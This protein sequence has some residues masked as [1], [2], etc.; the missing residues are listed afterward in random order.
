VLACE[1]PEGAT[2]GST[3]HVI[4]PAN[5]YY[6]V[7]VPENAAPGDTINILFEQQEFEG[8]SSPTEDAPARAEKKSISARLLASLV[9][10]SLKLHQ[11]A[12][13]IDND[14]K[15]TEKVTEKVT[16][17][18]QKYEISSKT[19]AF[20]IPYVERATVLD[21]EYKVTERVMATG[22]RICVFAKE[23]DEKYA[24]SAR[25]G[26]FVTVSRGKIEQ[27]IETAKVVQQDVKGSIPIV[28]ANTKEA[29]NT[30]IAKAQ[31]T[32]QAAIA[33]V[34]EQKKA[35]VV[36][37]T[38]AVN[39]AMEKTMEISTN[40]SKMALD[41]GVSALDKAISAAGGLREYVHNAS[42]SLE[43]KESHS[44]GAGGKAASGTGYTPVPVADAINELGL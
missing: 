34:K 40:L 27:A 33:A 37:T 2:A 35:V 10:L 44:E 18:D 29:I 9:A 22:T 32:S 6:E 20:L 14:Y 39:T 5:K 30:T 13:K 28:V 36:G 43:A 26:R 12:V 8:G 38:A 15:I 25:V 23:V 3:F 16:S 4:S 31:E 1:V 24:I 7:I 41:S 42:K 11:T 17:I 19:K 21:N